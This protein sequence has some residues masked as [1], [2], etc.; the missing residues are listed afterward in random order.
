MTAGMVIAIEPRIN[1]GTE[2]LN[3]LD[4]G[5]TVATADHKLSA[6]WEHTIAIFKDHTEILTEPLGLLTD[7]IEALPK[8]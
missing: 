2:H 8:L 7:P 5:W 6:H 3:I 1:Q 4:D